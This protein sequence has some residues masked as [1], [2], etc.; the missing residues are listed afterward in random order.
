MQIAN[1]NLILNKFGSSIP[2]RGVSPGEYKA[3]LVEHGANV[4]G[5]VIE[6]KTFE[7]VGDKQVV[8]RR[9]EVLGEDGKP[10]IGPDG[11]PVLKVIGRTITPPEEMALLR[12]KYKRT[13]LEGLYPGLNPDLL[14]RTFKELGVSDDGTVAVSAGDAPIEVINGDSIE[15]ITLPHSGTALLPATDGVSQPRGAAPDPKQPVERLSGSPGNLA[16]ALGKTSDDG[17]RAE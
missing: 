8:V 17:G 9:E 1:F 14:P 2:K 12:R 4:G 10:K 13:T 6:S 16:F 15:V 11:K 7:L 5:S 3:M